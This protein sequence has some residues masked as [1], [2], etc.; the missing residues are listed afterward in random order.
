M[1]ETP[2]MLKIEKKFLAPGHRNEIGRIFLISTQPEHFQLRHH[3][4]DGPVI[5]LGNLQ[6]SVVTHL[7]HYVVVPIKFVNFLP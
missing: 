6:Y 4:P 3:F 2:D 7:L 5:C 1:S